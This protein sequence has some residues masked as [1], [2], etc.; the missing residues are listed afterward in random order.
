MK[1]PL[2]PAFTLIEFLIAIGLVGCIASFAAF[3]SI[4]SFQVVV[5]K[6][7]ADEQSLQ[8]EAVAGAAYR[9]I[10]ADYLPL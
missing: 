10:S 7:Q 2:F 1:D 6:L 3:Q 9:G 5:Q 8:A 4:G